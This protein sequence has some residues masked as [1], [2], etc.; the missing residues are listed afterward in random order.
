MNLSFHSRFKRLK[1]SNLTHVGG[2][3]QQLRNMALASSVGV[4]GELS[5]LYF[6]SHF[7]NISSC[8]ELSS[9]SNIIIFTQTWKSF[10]SL[11]CAIQSS[12][13]SKYQLTLF[14]NFHQ[15][16]SYRMAQGRINAWFPTR[17][18]M[19]VLGPSFSPSSSIHKSSC[20]D[21]QFQK[22]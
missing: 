20:S 8:S 5:L 13:N 21:N 9:S 18:L 19:I 22:V 3:W 11:C 10:F 17:Y 1:I 12:P 16:F 15:P 7:Y 4:G 2:S 6:K 14:S